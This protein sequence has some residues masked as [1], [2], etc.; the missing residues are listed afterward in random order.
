MY[1]DHQGQAPP[2]APQQQSQALYDGATATNRATGQR[3]IYRISTG[4]RGRWVALNA[5]TADPQAR[6]R[7]ENMQSMVNVGQRTLPQA[8]R[9]LQ[10]NFRV[11]TGGIQNDPEMPAWIRST[12]G[13]LGGGDAITNADQMRALSSQMVGSN[14]QPG[15]TGM[16]NTS[17]E[18]EQARQRF[19]APT[20]RGAA[21]A[22]VYTNM[23]E[24][25]M[26]Q[27][28]ALADMRR[29]LGDHPNLNEWDAQWSRREGEVRQRARDDAGRWLRQEQTNSRSGRPNIMIDENGNRI[30]R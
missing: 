11:P 16:F 1:D 7:V 28:E 4:G 26:V 2:E 5:E 23:Y 8:Q 25:M 15:T 19:P 10:R 30:T 18:M 9:F 20:N 3:I 17:T 22:D 6:E 14:W 27:R 29:W 24:D 21:N 13:A 12:I